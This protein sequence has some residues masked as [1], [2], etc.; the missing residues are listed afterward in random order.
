[1]GPVTRMSKGGLVRTCP[2]LFKNLILLKINKTEN[3]WFAI[4][5]VHAVQSIITKENHSNK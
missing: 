2:F 4:Q 5:V 3:S 1:M